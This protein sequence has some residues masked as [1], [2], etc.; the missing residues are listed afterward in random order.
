MLETPF[1]GDISGDVNVGL[2]LAGDDK[3][4][5]PRSNL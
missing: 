3:A 2:S 5:G 1:T 4:Y